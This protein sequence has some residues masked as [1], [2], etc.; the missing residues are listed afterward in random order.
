MTIRDDVLATVND[1]GDPLMIDIEERL[2]L[3]CPPSV[4]RDVVK[5]A[6]RNGLLRTKDDDIDHAV[7]YLLTEK[8][9]Q[10]VGPTETSP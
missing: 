8:G 10:A 6:V 9:R 3:R 2:S 5:T 7:A 1:I 4:V